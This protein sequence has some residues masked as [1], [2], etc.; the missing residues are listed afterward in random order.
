MLPKPNVEFL[1]NERP[2]GTPWT[3]E[4][5]RGIVCNPIYAGIPPFPGLRSDE[6][7]IKTAVKTIEREGE[8]QFLVNLLFL[9]RKTYAGQ[10]RIAP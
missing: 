4:E 3:P 6:E 5:A 1:T 10:Q 7:W 9:L 2:E 8:E